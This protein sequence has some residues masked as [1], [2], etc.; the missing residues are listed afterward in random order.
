MARLRLGLVE[1]P[2]RDGNLRRIKELRRHGH[3]AVHQVGL[4]Q[5]PPDVTLAAALARWPARRPHAPSGPD[6][7]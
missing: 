4:D 3:D 7:G 5:S 1:E 2:D 6:G